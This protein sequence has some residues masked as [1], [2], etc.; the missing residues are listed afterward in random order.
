MALSREEVSERVKAVLPNILPW[1]QLQHEIKRLNAR[2]EEL[3]A[4]L[5]S[6]TP[7]D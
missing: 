2:I 5:E 3:E 4:K 6:L 7:Q 1:Q